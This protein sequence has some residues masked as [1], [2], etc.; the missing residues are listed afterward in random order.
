[1][2]RL[3][4]D[5]H[6]EVTQACEALQKAEVVPQE[7][8]EIIAT[9]VLL[10]V[11]TPNEGGEDTTLVNRIRAELIDHVSSLG[12]TVLPIRRSVSQRLDGPVNGPPAA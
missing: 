3:R 4:S 7:E 5:I 8:L 2:S 12:V 6:I 9:D 10:R 1:M 11:R